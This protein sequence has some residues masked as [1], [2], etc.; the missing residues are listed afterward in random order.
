MNTRILV[1][2][3]LFVLACGG[4]GGTPGDPNAS[5]ATP[6][7]VFTGLDAYDSMTVQDGFVYVELP[8]QGVERCPVAG[9]TFPTSVVDNPAFIASAMGDQGITYTTQIAA[10]DGTV[11][12][13]MRSIAMD[14]TGDQSVASSLSYPAW[15]ATSGARV[16]W[17]QDAFAF[18]DTPATIECIGCGGNAATPWITGLTGGTYGMTTDQTNV[19]V[20]VD[21]ATQTALTLLSCSLDQPCFSEPHVVLDQLDPTTTMAQIA[22][23]GSSVYVARVG[24]D[25]IVRVDASGSVTTALSATDVVT[26]IA[27]DPKTHALYYGTSG[28]LVGSATSTLACTTGPIAGLALDD[29][30]VYMLTGASGSDVLRIAR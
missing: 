25:D 29:A 13:D 28:G 1:I 9:C 20:L 27:I 5:C 19:Y 11:S 6:S 17:A 21:N 26:A 4:G 30:N 23:D 10:D 12:G 2:A 7:V 24:H 16:F 8:G 15:V 14:G 22:S 18:D 3:S